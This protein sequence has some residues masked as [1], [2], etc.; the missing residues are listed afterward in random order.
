MRLSRRKFA[1]LVGLTA[2]G[3]MSALAYAASSP[4]EALS[5]ILK[6]SQSKG[7]KS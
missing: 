1:S 4:A 7:E 3:G 5:N 6:E 2:C